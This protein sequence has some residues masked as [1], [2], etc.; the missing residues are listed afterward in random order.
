VSAVRAAGERG[1]IDRVRSALLRPGVAVF[2]LVLAGYA[3]F[4]QAGGWN[5]NSRFD[6]TRAIVEQGSL[7]IDRY[8]RNTGDA[9]R[10]AGHMYCDKAPGVS[11][12]AV[13]AWA[14]VHAAAPAP[15]RPATLATGAWLATVTAVGVPSALGVVA[16]LLL[17]AGL[18]LSVRRAA[19]V[20]LAWGLAT[21]AFPYSTLLYGHQLIAAMLVAAFALL[22]RSRGRDGGARVRS[23]VAV[24]ALLGG[25]VVVEYTAALAALPIAAY[26][27][28]VAPWRRAIGA[29]AAGA[30]GPALV[31]AAYHAAAFGGPLTL[32]YE[33]STQRHRHMGWFMGLGAPDLRVLGQITFSAYRGL[34]YT[35]PWLL[36]AVPGAIRWW[37]RGRR[38]EV[39][40]CAAI[41]VLFL[42]LNAS[43]VDW[44]GG[45]AIGPRY[46]IPAIPFLVVLAA[47]VVLPA[48]AGS[49]LARLFADR[50]AR[51]CAAIALAAVVAGSAAIMLIG[52]AVRPEIDVHVRRPVGFVLDHFA[53]GE[54]GISTQSIDMIGGNPNG[55]PEAWNLGHRIGLAGR[56]SLVPLVV[57]WAACAAWLGIALRR[58]PR[59]EAAAG[60]NS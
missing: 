28:R 40:V 39:G 50:R 33:F 55:P 43:L 7:Q 13:P 21:L 22:V 8:A 34:F 3:Y 41:V 5:Q 60:D 18:G 37:Q 27:L 54:L 42:W 4:Y 29:V 56:A 15:P 2:A 49:R 52:T 17:A 24:G 14:L 53:A 12:L 46:L 25:A 11:L 48:P 57:V 36:L 47:G 19:L 44:Q 38:A 59:H 20:A 16:M 32:P 10:R 35:T 51:A 45:W 31:L 26:A 6:L 23:L 9:S 58:L 30:V 1:V